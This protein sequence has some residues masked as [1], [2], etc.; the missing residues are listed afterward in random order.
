MEL[1][2]LET[3]YFPLDVTT[4]RNKIRMGYLEDLDLLY[5]HNENPK[6]IDFYDFSDKTLFQ[7]VEFDEIDSKRVLNKT[8]VHVLSPDSIYIYD[9]ITNKLVLYSDKGKELHHVGTVL[10]ENDKADYGIMPWCYFYRNY[11]GNFFFG[12]TIRGEPVKKTNASPV[13][14]YSESTNKK[15]FFGVWP[16]EY[17]KDNQ[18]S[19]SGPSFLEVDD[20]LYLSMGFSDKLQVLSSSGELIS[21]FLANSNLM[22][23]YRSINNKSSALE[24]SARYQLTNSRY[25]NLLYD[26]SSGYLIREGSIGSNIPDNVSPF[27]GE[28]FPSRNNDDIYFVLIIIDPKNGKVGEIQGSWIGNDSFSTKD[29]I[30]IQDKLTDPK[31]ED[32]LIVNKMRIK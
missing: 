26:K 27:S 7:T 4:L 30:Y 29:G 8:M 25:T 1:E 23:P 16:E 10:D 17:L 3:L 15:K 22:R 21:T 28:I 5:V 6:K 31:N 11:T 12:V 14:F 18:M 20:H 13:L 19:F 9:Q 24:E 32:V 2:H